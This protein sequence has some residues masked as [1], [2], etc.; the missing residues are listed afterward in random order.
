M[1]TVKSSDIQLYGI[2]RSGHHAIVYWILGHYNDYH[3]FNNCTVHN[4]IAKSEEFYKSANPVNPIVF[5][6]FED[7]QAELRK[8]SLKFIGKHLAPPRM[9]R[10]LV[11]RDPFNNYASR[12]KLGREFSSIYKETSIWKELAK[13]YL[14]MTD[15]LGSDV[16]KVNYN[17]WF[18]D[19]SYRKALSTHFGEFTDNNFN[20]VSK[21][22]G[23]SSFD[24]R[25]YN[26]KS[27]KMQTL[28]RWRE[29]INNDLFT[30]IVLNDT[31]LM[32]LSTK[33]F[34]NIFKI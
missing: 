10:V 30:R 12:F 6:S 4:G 25:R 7:R 17:K 1:H 14:G 24:H 29:Y 22:G 9:K 8:S 21:I 26:G 23:G 15:Y 34:G 5:L 19:V 3:Y 31:E 2:K 32:E 28:S 20:Y 18:K 33:I 13:E 27:D 16:I 11:I